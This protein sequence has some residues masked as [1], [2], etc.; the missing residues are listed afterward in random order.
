MLIPKLSNDL[1]T[2]HKEAFGGFLIEL[3]AR[4]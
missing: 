1:S 3:E 4:F 2:I